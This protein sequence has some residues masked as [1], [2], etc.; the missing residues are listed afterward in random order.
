MVNVVLS[1]VSVNFSSND[2]TRQNIS[3]IGMIN[4]IGINEYIFYGP[5]YVNKQIG[6]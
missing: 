5:L 6:F 2:I 4:K 3:I 1:Y